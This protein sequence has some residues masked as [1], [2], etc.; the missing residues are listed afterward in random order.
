MILY[1]GFGTNLGDRMANLQAAAKALKPV[2]TLLEVSS[3]YETEPWGYADQPAFYNQVVKGETKLEPLELLMFLKNLE[4]ELGRKPN[5]R[6]GPR[7]ID[8][9]IL[10]YGDQVIKI[11]GLT[12]PH[13]GLAERAFVLAPLAELAGEL[14]HPVSGMSIRELLTKVATSGIKKVGSPGPDGWAPDKDRV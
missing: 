14:H 13:P 6:N 10:L 11:P 5:F 1:L 2:V 4:G 9:D 12:I 3:V 7:L 8:L